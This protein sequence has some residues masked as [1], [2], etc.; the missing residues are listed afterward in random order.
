[1]A[2]I[3]QLDS[4]PVPCQALESQLHIGETLELDLKPQTLVHS[5]VPLGI[6]RGFRVRPNRIQL[7]PQGLSVLGPIAFG[8]AGSIA[9]ATTRIAVR[10]GC[11]YSLE[12]EVLVLTV[13]SVRHVEM[14][15]RLRPLLPKS[16]AGR[17]QLLKHRTDILLS[18][19]HSARNQ[20]I[21]DHVVRGP[22][23]FRIA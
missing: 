12:N 10:L 13:A 23:H 14:V 2:D 5:C 20:R 11:R 6:C 19:P 3:Q 9:A 16:V 1:M 7:P 22:R 4:G 18:D 8:N 21:L 17:F 15:R